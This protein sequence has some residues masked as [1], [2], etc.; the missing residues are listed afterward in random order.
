[1][2]PESTL[3]LV[4][5]KKSL[6]AKVR[7]TAAVVPMGN[8][9]CSCKL[10]AYL[11]RRPFA[12]ANESYDWVIVNPDRFKSAVKSSIKVSAWLTAAVPV[13]SPYCSC[14]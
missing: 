12:K 10:N 6:R 11:G 2:A 7:L 4:Q 9:Y 8:P 1:M 3:S 5:F 14:K 13:D